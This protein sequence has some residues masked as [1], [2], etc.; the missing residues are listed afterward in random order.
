MRY[1]PCPG[2][3]VSSTRRPA[4]RRDAFIN[5]DKVSVQARGAYTERN[6]VS[7]HGLSG[8][9]SISQTS[10]ATSGRPT[11]SDPLDILNFTNLPQ[12][13]GVARLR[14]DHTLSSAASTPSVLP[15]TAGEPGTQ[16]ITKSFQRWST[17]RTCAHAAGVRYMLT[18]DEP[19]R[20]DGPLRTEGRSRFQGFAARRWERARIAKTGTPDRMIRVDRKGRSRHSSCRA[21]QRPRQK[22]AA[23]RGAPRCVLRP[24][25][26]G[27]SAATRNHRRPQGVE[28]QI[29]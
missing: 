8:D 21:A 15:R 27:A 19:R 22:T 20:S 7:C 24:L 14:D 3:P 29:R 9:L 28:R 18:V 1:G 23:R 13:L 17:R 25:S 4:A 26:C 16:L 12:G 6:A 5:Q 11:S 2:P 10:A